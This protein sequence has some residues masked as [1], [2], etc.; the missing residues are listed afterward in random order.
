MA[1][2]TKLILTLCSSSMSMASRFAVFIL[3]TLVSAAL[4]VSAAT[5]VY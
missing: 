1:K 5:V 3:A 4:S 2:P